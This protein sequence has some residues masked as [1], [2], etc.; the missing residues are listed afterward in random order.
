MK[1]LTIHCRACRRDVAARKVR[2]KT[3]AGWMWGAECVDCG[4]IHPTLAPGQAA[5]SR[6]R[7]AA[8]REVLRREAAGQL[9]LFPPAKGTT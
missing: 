2:V 6:G 7:R 5:A 3:R 1:P 9:T 8:R 4:V